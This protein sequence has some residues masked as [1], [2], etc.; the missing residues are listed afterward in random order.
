VLDFRSGVRRVLAAGRSPKYVPTGHLIYTTED[1]TLMARP[2]DLDRMDVTG[3]AIPILTGVGSDGGS[4]EISRSGRRMAYLRASGAIGNEVVWV[5][6]D[7]T[8]TQ[9]D[10]PWFGPAMVR[11]SPDGTQIVAASTPSTAE[12]G[13]QIEIRNLVD[14]ELTRLTFRE[15]DSSR[16]EWTSDGQHVS[17]LAR[18]EPTQAGAESNADLYWRRADRSTD[19][20]LLE[21]QDRTISQAIVGDDY[22]LL[23]VGGAAQGAKDIFAVSRSDGSSFPVADSAG[24]DE[25]APAL[26]PDQRY[27]AYVSDET[28][29]DEVWV[30]ELEPDGERWQ[31]STGGGTQPVWS[32]AGDEIY[33]KNGLNVLVSVTVRIEPSF[34][35]LS[36]EVGMFDFARYCCNP[37]HAH[38]DISSDNLRFVMT[39]RRGPGQLIMVDN[40]LGLLNRLAP[41][42]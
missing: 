28:A 6:R 10:P 41:T 5:E 12:G 18:A 35:Q 20:E 9:F 26:S 19:R 33:Y 37:N 21:D 34:V 32:N 13:G 15:V 1:E 39:V 24:V 27:V 23:R 25:R 11:V 31:I 3:P 22:Y 40:V 4:V 2:F 38:Y 8:E 36:Q 30:R 29:R 17:Y 14:G 7:G 16:P 42:N